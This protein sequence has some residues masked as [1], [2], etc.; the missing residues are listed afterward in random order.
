MKRIH[1]LIPHKAIQS[2][3]I[4]LSNLSSVRL[5]AGLFNLD[6]FNIHKFTANESIEDIDTLD[7]LF[8]GKLPNNAEHLVDKWSSYIK[9]QR[10]KNHKLFFDYT[11]HHL[12]NDIITGNFYLNNIKENDHVICASE[13]L[14]E[15]ISP[16]TK[17]ISVIP[18]PIEIDIQK[19]KKKKKSSLLFFGHHKNLKYLFKIIS[20]WESKVNTDLLIL[21]SHEGLN[22]IKTQ[23]QFIKKPP[24]LNIR[25][26][27]WSIDNMIKSAD[28]VSGII[29]PGDLED[30]AKNGVGNIRLITAF[31]LG[32]PVAAT[33]YNSYLEFENQFVN[34]DNQ[35]EFNL[36][37]ENPSIFSGRVEVAQKKLI[38]YTKEHIGLRWLDLIK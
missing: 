3:D 37:I 1:W 38:P 28:I 11:D 32:L 18:D 29:I 27:L 14:K 4:L 19:V 7:Y 26:Q 36:F 10:S 20:N 6:I 33:K 2:K 13:K 5:R 22:E 9:I 12:G 34:I 35:N 23:S 8:V 15:H 21:T 16:I 17:N 24:N 30:N 25:F 31:A